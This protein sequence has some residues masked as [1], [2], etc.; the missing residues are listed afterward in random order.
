MLS[1]IPVCIIVNWTQIQLHKRLL[2]FFLIKHWHGASIL[3]HVLI[4]ASTRIGAACVAM[5]RNTS[6]YAKLKTRILASNNFGQ[7]NLNNE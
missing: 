5:L 7:Q 2:K 4:R 1:C 3:K 6:Y